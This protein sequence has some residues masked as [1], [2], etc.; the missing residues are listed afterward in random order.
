MY[1]VCRLLLQFITTY[2]CLLSFPTRRSSDLMVLPKDSGIMVELTNAVAARIKRPIQFV[3]M[4][5][6]KARTDDAY[7][8]PLKGLK[9]GAGT[10]LYLGLIQIGRAHV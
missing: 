6:V 4:P 10:E 9:L 5:V 1:L 8:A 2:P 3:H 7:Y